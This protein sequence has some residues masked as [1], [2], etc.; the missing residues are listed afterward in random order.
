MLFSLLPGVP[1]GAASASEAQ[2]HDYPNELQAVD[3]ALLPAGAALVRLTFAR[4]AV[5]PP[6]VLVNHYP[7]HRITLDFPDT[8]TATG[9]RLIEV[10][11]RGLRSIQLVQ[12]GARTRVILNIDRPFL[13]DT[14]LRGR[15][16]LITLRRPNW[17][18]ARRG[19]RDS[20]AALP[21]RLAN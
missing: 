3:Y 5:A 9:K 16:L 13:F 2:Q 7:L 1:L 21:V 8:V 6:N 10:A 11:P 19:T 17:G 15:E 14:V 18:V 12:S 20:G 4:P